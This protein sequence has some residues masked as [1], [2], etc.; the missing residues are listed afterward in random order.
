MNGGRRRQRFTNAISG[1]ANFLLRSAPAV[2]SPDMVILHG[3]LGGCSSIGEAMRAAK[4]LLR[5]ALPR[6][7]TGSQPEDRVVAGRQQ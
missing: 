5:S 7:D 2:P 6:A 1:D 3:R 4:R